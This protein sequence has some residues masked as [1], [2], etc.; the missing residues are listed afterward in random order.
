MAMGGTRQPTADP[1][2][3]TAK[4]ARN[5]E[6]SLATIAPGTI[7]NN[8]DLATTPLIFTLKLY[9]LNIVHSMVHMKEI[10][11]CTSTQKK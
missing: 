2:K 11:E 6:T 4:V 5:S 3:A 8:P 9:I 1:W 7:G 10:T